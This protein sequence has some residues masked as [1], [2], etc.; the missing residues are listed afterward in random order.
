MPLVT[1]LESSRQDLNPGSQAPASVLLITH[2]T[3]LASRS[4]STEA[5]LIMLRN[6][7]WPHKGLG[8][9][10][11]LNRTENFSDWPLGGPAWRP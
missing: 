5:S 8:D 1:Q 10:A 3:A 2:C 6:P 9:L 11:D 7:Q 4:Q